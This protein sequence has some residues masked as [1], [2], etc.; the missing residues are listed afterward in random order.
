MNVSDL[1][2]ICDTIFACTANKS[3]PDTQFL[4]VKQITIIVYWKQGSVQWCNIL[5][6]L[7]FQNKISEKKNIK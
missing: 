3:S 7:Y 4:D 2:A 6:V 5:I 1:I